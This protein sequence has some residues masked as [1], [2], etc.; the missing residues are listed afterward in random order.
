MLDLRDLE[1]SETARHWF[2]QQAA[3]AS[4]EE[5]EW[6]ERRARIGRDEEDS[7]G[8]LD[9]FCSFE[10]VLEDVQYVHAEQSPAWWEYDWVR[11]Y[12]ASL[13][14]EPD[15]LERFDEDFG[16]YR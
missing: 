9:D 14:H 16:L 11:D 15:S 6:D 8:D 10:D 3:E 1:R 13:S 4:D 12:L 7:T 2:A 5:E